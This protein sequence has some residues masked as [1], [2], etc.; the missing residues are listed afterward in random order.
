MLYRRKIVLNLLDAIQ[1]Q[2]DKI[3]FM[4]LL[5][6]L[7]TEG[8]V[9]CYDFV[10]YL[11][12]CF[13]FTAYSDLQS[14]ANDNLVD[15]QHGPHDIVLLNFSPSTHRIKAADRAAIDWLWARFRETSQEDL[16][17]YTYEHFPF[18]AAKTTLKH[19]VTPKMK[20][21]LTCI[22]PSSEDV[23]LYTIGYEGK[24][25][26]RYFDLLLL[27]GVKVLID[28]RKNPISMKYGFSKPSL[29]RCAA[30]LGVEY[31]HLPDLGIES[32]KRQNLSGLADY[33]KL[34]ANYE[35]TVLPRATSS[36]KSILAM[37][38]QK[39]RVALT[40]FE[41]DSTYCHRSRIAQYLKSLPSGKF[42]IHHL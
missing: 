15:F 27:K 21:D 17:R 35:K 41:A 16:I 4:K 12:G 19:F 36:L 3:S 37:L 14:M 25:L 11:Q 10:P 38:H 20:K 1:R 2:I 30:K 6:L 42:T 23:V 13:S 18:Y 40:C 9:P 32:A 8:G 31:I 5:F 39:R 34:F 29:A 26:E 22:F 28:V 7:S 33:E 24:S